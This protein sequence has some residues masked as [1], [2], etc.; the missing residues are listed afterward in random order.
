MMRFLSFL[1]VVQ[2]SIFS[3]VS[4]TSSQSEDE[5]NVDGAIEDSEFS[6]AALDEGN[7]V[8][9][10]TTTEEGA[11]GEDALEDELDG[12][13]QIVAA[14]DAELDDQALA[15]DDQIQGLDDDSLSE[16]L[17]EEDLQEQS[18]PNPAEA[19]PQDLPVADTTPEQLAPPPEPAP[20][21]AKVRDIRFLSNSSGGTVVI[22]TSQPVQYQTRMNAA[23]QQFVIEMAEVELP[24]SLQRP[25]QMNGMG[26][27]FGSVN[28][29]Q[30]ASSKTARVVIQMAGAGSGE[31]MIQ[32]EGSSLVIIPPPIAPPVATVAKVADPKS[33]TANQ[34]P[35]AART[36]DEFLTGNQRFFGRGISMQ[37][38]DADVRDVIN[39][40][41]EESGA[42][43]VMSDDVTGKISLKLR[44]IP[45][46]QALVTVMRAK[47]LGYTRQGNV[48]RIST[49]ASLQSE[50][51]AANKI[52]EAQRA[53]VPSVVQ[54]IPASYAN[55]E[56][57]IKSVTPFLSKDGKVIG[58]NRTNTVIVT[59]KAEIV[60]RVNKLVRTL[61]VVPPQ[62]SIESKIVEAV[63]GFENFVGLNWNMSGS[64]LTL[65]PGGGAYGAPV[66]LTPRAQSSTLS[67]EFAGGSPLSAGLSFGVLDGLGTLA[68]T[69]QLAERNS[70]A[71]VI[72]APRIS[73]LN[74][75]ESTI[76][77][78]GEAVS[79]I[80]SRNEET[81][82]ITKSEK[83]TPFSLNLK[84][85]PQITAEGSVIMEL[86]VQRQF[87]GPV[88]DAETQARAVNSRSA[89]TKVLVRNGQ[90]AV[91]GGIYTSDETEATNGVPGLMRIPVIGWLF[92][93]RAINR[94]KNELL[95][96]MTP[97][98]LAADGNGAEI[99]NVKSVQ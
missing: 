14:D 44:K 8:A 24:A 80:T 94:T 98:I 52:L 56:D 36:L 29:Y 96:F 30:G 50:T 22:E 51:E 15:E 18:T 9:S 12:D 49:L 21:L 99:T 62:V 83:R 33:A 48:L 13:D 82:T 25:F 35:L 77:Q 84:V 81:N 53:I 27:Q 65:S 7:G 59:D 78:Q 64:P 86:D 5:A 68:A 45:W 39:F 16:E 37:F 19:P 10:D 73:T 38:K 92:K 85:R 60:E 89:K 63:E 17:A 91:I 23:T 34:G 46:D 2:F 70:L 31:P 67:S 97:R 42:N 76:T 95:I 32:Q 40:V 20:E 61:D 69:L 1:L 93:N 57:L 11:S 58:D 26:S 43:I 72:S 88:V 3:L 4:C 87:L 90:T 74:R 79:I 54:V 55:I 41:A 6:D 71:K 75:E 47:S 66:T 28:A